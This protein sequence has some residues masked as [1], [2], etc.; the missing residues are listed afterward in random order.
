M[1]VSEPLRRRNAGI[2][3]IIL[4]VLVVI[5]GATTVALLPMK[6]TLT[7][8]ALQESQEWLDAFVDGRGEALDAWLSSGLQQVGSVA[9]FPEV[10]RLAASSEGRHRV[11]EH[12]DTMVRSFGVHSAA[13]FGPDG[14]ELVTSSRTSGVPGS[15]LKPF[16]RAAV[17][18]TPPVILERHISDGIAVTFRLPIRGAVPGTSRGLAV[19]RHYP[20]QRLLAELTRPPGTAQPV[21]I[22]LLVESADGV[23]YALTADGEVTVAPPWLRGGLPV[24]AR[25]WPKDRLSTGGDIE[26]TGTPDQA[27]LASVHSVR[28]ADWWLVGTIERGPILVRVESEVRRSGAVVYLALIALASATVGVWRHWRASHYRALAGSQAR[29]RSIFDGAPIPLLE[30][31]LS[32]V[33]SFLEDEARQ[34]DGFCGDPDAHPELKREL[35]ALIRMASVNRAGLELLGVISPEELSGMFG[36]LFPD[37]A[38][39]LLC[40]WWESVLEGK[41]E[42]ETERDLQPIHGGLRQVLLRVRNPDSSDGYGRVLVSILDLTVARALEE[43]LRQ[44]QKMEAVGRLAGGVAHDFNNLLQAMLVAADGLRLSAGDRQRTEETAAELSD[45]VRRAGALTRQLLLFSRRETAKLEHLDLNEVV[46]GMTKL[47]RRLIREN[48]SFHVEPD[49]HSLSL[50][51]D[52]GQ[53]E[54]VLLNLVVNAVDAMPD[55]GSLVVRTAAEG[56]KTI[57]LEVG[58]TGHGIPHEVRDRVFEPFFT[59]KAA[60]EG[61]GLGLSVVHGIVASHG[62]TIDVESLES[63]G[64]TVRVLLPRATGDPD[65]AKGVA[66][67]SGLPRGRG[68]LILVVEDNPTVRTSLVETLTTLGYAV[69]EAESGEEAAV[70]EGVRPHVLLTDYLLPGMTGLEL[71]KRCHAR[72]PN[73]RV[74]LMS[75]YGGDHQLDEAV[76]A[77]SISFLRKPASLIDLAEELRRVLQ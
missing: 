28:G 67:G 71:A 43:Q 4:A 38:A 22:W 48:I 55:G 32:A 45:L 63:R 41:S 19:L 60:G 53:V 49:Q 72:W 25:R 34:R 36:A 46:L 54:Q 29:F 47:L 74:I 7:K 39:Q 44:A 24:P 77:G 66:A 27:H 18:A 69:A 61:T 2:A 17:S 9:D 35:T 51:A 76:R 21:S 15:E 1:R 20:S 14:A 68:E 59:T 26:V 13:V 10:V 37:G 64:T 33:T 16:E 3:V 57:V 56:D 8:Q 73:L 58:D 42:F 65:S 12:L 62:G 70:I 31:D 23:I 52:R 75:G 40:E 11:Q 50:R 6:E 30:L 5:W